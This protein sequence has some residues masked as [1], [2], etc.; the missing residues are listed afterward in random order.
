MEEYENDVDFGWSHS[1]HCPRSGGSLGRQGKE[2]SWPLKEQHMTMVGTV[3]IF[4]LPKLTTTSKALFFY[5]LYSTTESSIQLKRNKK[6][7]SMMIGC[8]IYLLGFF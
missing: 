3:V 8:K 1:C 2:T 7:N 5:L 6:L 4:I